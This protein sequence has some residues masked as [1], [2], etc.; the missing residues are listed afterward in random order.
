[1][2]M[3][4]AIADRHGLAVVED[5]G[6]SHGATFR[7]RRAGSWGH[8]AFGLYG[9]GQGGLITTDDDRLADWIRRYRDHGRRGRQ[10][11]ILGF[12]F[13]LSEVAGAIGLVGLDR[14][15]P[16]IA[17]RRAIAGR[18][19]AALSEL[20]IRRPL[21]P[22]GRKHVFHRYVL[23]VGRARDAIVADL[24]A[25]GVEAAVDY[26]LP[27][28]RQPY[29]M[30]RGIDADL[31]ITDAAADGLLGLPIYAGLTAAEEARVIEVVRAAVA[32]HVRE[33]VRHP[34]RA[35]VRAASAPR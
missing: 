3:I 10:A 24:A 32:R 26:P 1:M 28:H 18:Y 35:P 6:G 29:V 20:P 34:T 21:V 27:I 2:D 14:I 22:V 7:G 25:A 30:E 15:G 9:A 19:D 16:G 23:G 4:S 17:I 8:G 33:S 11:E 12:D 5:G 31:P 13:H